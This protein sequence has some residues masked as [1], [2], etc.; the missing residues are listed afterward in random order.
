MIMRVLKILFAAFLAAV[1]V[2]AGLFAAAVIATTAA[3]ALL[4][5]RFRHRTA[6]THRQ[7]PAASPT[8]S[9]GPTD[10]IDIS[11]TEVS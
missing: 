3:V 8:R 4:I 10:A 2:L 1:A 7:V 5:R 9:T 6:P 11:A